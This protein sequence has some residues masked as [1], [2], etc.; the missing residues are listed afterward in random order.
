MTR[1][2][3]IPQSPR[4]PPSTA[5]TPSS[6][7]AAAT[8]DSDGPSALV[9]ELTPDAPAGTADV[10]DASGA[11]RRSSR[12]PRP[13]SARFFLEEFRTL[14][15]RDVVA[16]ESRARARITEAAPIEEKVA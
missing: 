14:A 15:S 7:A 4:P 5:S 10:A 9:A 16:F 3:E 2:G 11:T 8:L 6:A 12:A 13:G 1:S